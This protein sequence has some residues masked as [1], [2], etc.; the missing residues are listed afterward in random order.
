MCYNCS[1]RLSSS[2]STFSVTGLWIW[3]KNIRQWMWASN[4]NPKYLNWGNWKE[5]FKCYLLKAD[6]DSDNSIT[7]KHQG[8]CTGILIFKLLCIAHWSPCSPWCK[9]RAGFLRSNFK[10]WETL[11]SSIHKLRT[12]LFHCR[13]QNRGPESARDL[14]SITQDL[15]FSL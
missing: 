5:D 8:Q 2:L 14:F 3:W 13:V 7:K 10:K 1:L 9:K 15:P 6:C 12:S 11:R 4:G